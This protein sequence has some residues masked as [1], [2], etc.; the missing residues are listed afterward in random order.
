MSNGEFMLVGEDQLRSRIVRPSNIRMPREDRTMLRMQATT[1]F[2]CSMPPSPVM[3]PSQLVGTSTATLV[4]ATLDSNIQP[5]V[6]TDWPTVPATTAAAMP[7]ETRMEDDSSPAIQ[8]NHS[9]LWTFSPHFPTRA[10]MTS[11]ELT[12]PQS[13]VTQSPITLYQC[14]N[15]QGTSYFLPLTLS[16]PATIRPMGFIPNFAVLQPA[17]PVDADSAISAQPDLEIES[18]AEQANDSE[19]PFIQNELPTDQTVVE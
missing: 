2:S 4:H 1:T 9:P 6:R 7:I 14:S 17:P 16:P 18:S 15:I 3:P 5:E 12:P 19:Q 10:I 11:V 13:S 8:L